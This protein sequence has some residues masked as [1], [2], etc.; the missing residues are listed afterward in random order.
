MEGEDIRASVVDGQLTVR[1]CCANLHVTVANGDLDLSY[2][3]CGPRPF[4]A[5]AQVTHGS[6]QL[7][8]PRDASFHARA[9]TTKGR[10][11]NDFA[12]MVDVNGR[13]LQKIDVSVGAKA[14]SEVAIH[15]TTGDI[16]IVALKSDPAAGPRTAST[17]GSN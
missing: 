2:S 12:D 16:R 8:I 3:H 13:L 7:S 11:V 1:D 17:T 6:A 4:F 14:R 9:Q 5:E 15:V 10:V